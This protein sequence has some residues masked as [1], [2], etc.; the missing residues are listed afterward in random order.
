MKKSKKKTSE[1][2]YA[3]E[4]RKIWQHK[5][6]GFAKDKFSSPNKGAGATST[7]LYRVYN[8]CMGATK[9]NLGGVKKWDLVK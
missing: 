2:K 5:T 6:E 8:F 7:V 3:S 9:N 4:R 1:R